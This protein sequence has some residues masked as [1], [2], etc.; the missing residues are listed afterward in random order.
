M[1]KVTAQDLD[2]VAL[3]YL[4]GRYVPWWGVVLKALA[5]L[6]LRRDEVGPALQAAAAVWRHLQ[7]V[8]RHSPALWTQIIRTVRQE[9]PGALLSRME[10]EDGAFLFGRVL[11]AHAA[12]RPAGHV[13]LYGLEVSVIVTVLHVPGALGDA[14]KVALERHV[15]PLLQEEAALAAQPGTEQNRA[16]RAALQGLSTQSTSFAADLTRFARVW[17]QSA[18][19]SATTSAR[20]AA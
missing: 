5:R 19:S 2:R 8:R 14:L 4:W 15:Q 17:G 3:G 10:A 20:A 6:Y 16:L 18:G 12:E 9:L 1:R 7:E 13:A 11:R